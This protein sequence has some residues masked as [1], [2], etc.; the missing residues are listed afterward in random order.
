MKKIALVLACA[1]SLALAGCGQGDDKPAAT[2]T[3]TA[4]AEATDDA[5]AAPSDD[6]AVDAAASE[7]ASDTGNRVPPKS[8]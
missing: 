6:P 4:S 3:A 7:G 8:N 5:S 2:D 1:G